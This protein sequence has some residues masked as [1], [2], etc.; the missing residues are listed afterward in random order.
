M[1]TLFYERLVAHRFFYSAAARS[2]GKVTKMILRG[3]T[4]L[5]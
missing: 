3:R 5:R 2:R 1:Q 4:P